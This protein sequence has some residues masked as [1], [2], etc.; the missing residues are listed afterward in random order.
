MFQ[1]AYRQ[2]LSVET[3]LVRVYNGIMRAFDD[4]KYFML[5]LL[6]L[7]VTF[8]SVDHDRLLSVLNLRIGIQGAALSYFESYLRGRTQRVAIKNVQ[9]SLTKLKCD[10]PRRSALVPVMFTTYF[11]PLWDILWKF[12]VQFHCYADA[13]QLYIP[14]SQ[15][16]HACLGSIEECIAKIPNWMKSNFL[17]LNA[18]KNMAILSSPCFAKAW[19]HD[20]M[21]ELNGELI[22]PNKA[23]RNLGVFFDKTIKWKAM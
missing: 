13:T 8:E 18:E 4:K 3:A 19:T 2:W 1:S 10:V 22:H 7:R 9:S 23:V 16:G 15:N 12:G 11:L 14:F 5:V 6:N 21:I 17:K 20:M